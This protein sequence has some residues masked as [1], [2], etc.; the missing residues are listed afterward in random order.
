LGAGVPY[1]GAL[2]PPVPALP[3]RADEPLPPYAP[4]PTEV[5]GCGAEL[6]PGAV[7]LPVVVYGLPL[8]TSLRMLRQPEAETTI[9][10]A[11]VSEQ[12][13]ITRLSRSIDMNSS[14]LGT[15]YR[16]GIKAKMS[17]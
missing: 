16:G 17:L 12:P 2:A 6:K 11:M 4:F 1:W 10:R 9:P 14:F 15:R 3:S 8:G 5:L 7:G 13:A